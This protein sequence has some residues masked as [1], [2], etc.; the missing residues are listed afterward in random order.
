MIRLPNPKNDPPDNLRIK[1]GILYGRSL[2]EDPAIKCQNVVS[3]VRT[4]KSIMY[5]AELLELEIFDDQFNFKTTLGRFLEYQA[6]GANQGLNDYTSGKMGYAVEK[7]NGV[8]SALF[9]ILDDE[10]FVIE[11]KNSFA[12]VERK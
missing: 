6:F 11:D 10:R 7:S 1:A 5:H 9:F 12:G 3:L 2:S 4:I 8:L